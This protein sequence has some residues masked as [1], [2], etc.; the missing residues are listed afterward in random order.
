[1][2][3]VVAFVL[4]VAL[5]F[6]F[7]ELVNWLTAEPPKHVYHVLPDGKVKPIGG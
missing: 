6:G 3:A 4:A 1:M 5:G 7:I 2:K